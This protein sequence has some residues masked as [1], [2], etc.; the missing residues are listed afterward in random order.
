MTKVIV[1]AFTVAVF[2]L[3]VSPAARRWLAGWWRQ[4][5]EVL[6]E[7]ELAQHNAKS[8]RFHLDSLGRFFELQRESRR[9]EK[10]YLKSL[11]A[12]NTQ[13]ATLKKHEAMLEEEEAAKTNERAIYFGE[14]VLMQDV[15]LYKSK[16]SMPFQD[17]DRLVRAYNNLA[18]HGRIVGKYIEGFT[19]IQ[20]NNLD[21]WRSLHLEINKELAR[22]NEL[23][24]QVKHPAPY[25]L[26]RDQRKAAQD[27]A[28][29][30]TKRPFV[31]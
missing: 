5:K 31:F 9:C 19:H 18:L 28:F 1:I 7:K 15:L 3:L 29:A 10:F 6:V 13:L 21:A 16:G 4:R 22:V 20:P 23:L 30:N 26:L 14:L 8:E 27:A 12:A 24:N 2:L 11:E 25:T 17:R